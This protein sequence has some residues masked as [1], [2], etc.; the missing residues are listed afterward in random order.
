MAKSGKRVLNKEVMSVIQTV[1][2]FLQK[3]L[4]YMEQQW[5]WGKLCSCWTAVP[6]LSVLQARSLVRSSYLRKLGWSWW[7]WRKSWKK[8][9]QRLLT[10]AWEWLKIQ[11]LKLATQLGYT[12]VVLQLQLSYARLWWGDSF[13]GFRPGL[14]GVL[15][16]HHA[17]RGGNGLL[18]IPLPLF[19][20]GSSSYLPFHRS[21][22]CS[23]CFL[24]CRT[25]ERHSMFI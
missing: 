13:L 10:C 16:S 1:K 23:C 14:S 25:K 24:I 11:V 12:T 19:I 9:L 17:H 4:Q 21:T 5:Q 2:Y 20:S 15:L 18:P 7:F 22:A 3:Y 6:E 8:A